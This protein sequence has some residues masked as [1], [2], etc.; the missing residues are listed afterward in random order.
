M[1]CKN[2]NCLTAYYIV[3]VC[4]HTHLKIDTCVSVCKCRNHFENKHTH[5]NYT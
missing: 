4:A 2:A 3:F 5:R 1:K